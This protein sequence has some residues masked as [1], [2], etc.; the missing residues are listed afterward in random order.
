MK[1]GKLNEALSLSQYHVTPTYTQYVTLSPAV[2]QDMKT[3]LAPRCVKD[4]KEPID[5]F[6]H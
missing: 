3:T 4:C 1:T 6:M 2:L 5:R